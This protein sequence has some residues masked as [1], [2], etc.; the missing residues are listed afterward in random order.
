MVTV[1]NRRT[2]EQ[3]YVTWLKAEEKL[4]VDESK[5]TPGNGKTQSQLFGMEGSFRKLS[6]D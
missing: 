5:R 4:R 6:F 1:E 3:Q 2:M